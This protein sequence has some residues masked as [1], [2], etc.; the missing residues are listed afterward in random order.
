MTE[1]S[2]IRS[3]GL[4]ADQV[5]FEHVPSPPEPIQ[6]IESGSTRRSETESLR[7][8]VPIQVLT[9]VA[10][11]FRLRHCRDPSSP[12]RPRPNGLGHVGSDMVRRDSSIPFRSPRASRC[13]AMFYAD[14]INLHSYKVA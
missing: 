10:L 2:S 1:P 5:P 7:F 11:A 6:S 3:P 9:M 14:M 12:T 8:A 4:G 13:Q